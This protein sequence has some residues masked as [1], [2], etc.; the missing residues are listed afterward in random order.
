MGMPEMGAEDVEESIAMMEAQLGIEL[1]DLYEALS[2]EYS[3]ALTYEA[4][5]LAGDPSMPIGLLLQFEN[6]DE[7]TFKQLMSL[8]GMALAGQGGGMELETGTIN[9]VSVTSLV[10]PNGEPLVGWGLSDE[11]FAL[12]TSQGL[13][14]MA[15]EGG[16]SLAD[17]ATFQAA[18]APLPEETGGYFYLKVA[19]TLEIVYQALSPYEQEGF[20]EARDILG[21]IKA[22]SSASEP[23]SREKDSASATVF[24]LLEE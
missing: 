20:E 9:D 10:G 11:F 12:G 15:F 19:G 5:G 18:M 2:G 22:I 3:L 13:L 17:D 24:I 14:E 23:M 6:K 16:D 4:A 21:P 1:D 7:A 8:A